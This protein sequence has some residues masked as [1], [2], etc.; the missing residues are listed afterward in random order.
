VLILVIFLNDEYVSIYVT[1]YRL[2]NFFLGGRDADVVDSSYQKK[3][4]K[5]SNWNR[6]VFVEEIKSILGDYSKNSILWCDRQ[7]FFFFFTEIMSRACIRTR[8]GNLLLRRYILG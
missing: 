3:K 1:W 6:D 2:Y 4:K 8:Q 5:K 7:L